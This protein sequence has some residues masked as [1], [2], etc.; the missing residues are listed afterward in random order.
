M[1][2]AELKK[3]DEKLS[4][5]YGAKTELACQLGCDS[6]K[7]TKFFRGMVKSKDFMARL[8]AHADKILSE[9]SEKEAIPG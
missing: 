2:P 8:Q 9:P 3:L 6:S 4:A 1:S 5:R 7:I